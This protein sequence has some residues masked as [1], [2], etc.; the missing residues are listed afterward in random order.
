MEKLKSAD[1]K[2]KIRSLVSGF[3]AANQ[4]PDLSDDEFELQLRRIDQRFGDLIPKQRIGR[5]RGAGVDF[6]YDDRL[7]VP[8]AWA[9]YHRGISGR[10]PIYVQQAL[11]RDL[12][13]AGVLPERL[14]WIFDYFYDRAIVE[15][16]N[17]EAATPEAFQIALQ[18]ILVSRESDI[19]FEWNTKIIRT[20]LREEPSPSQTPSPNPHPHIGEASLLAMGVDQTL[21]GPE[22][23]TGHHRLM[24]PDEETIREFHQRRVEVREL[25]RG[26][27]DGDPAKAE[28]LERMGKGVW[29]SRPESEWIDDERMLRTRPPHL[30]DFVLLRL[31]WLAQDSGAGFIEALQDRFFACAN[32]GKLEILFRRGENKK[33]R[34]C[35][36]LP[37]VFLARGRRRR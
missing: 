18:S 19:A 37:P 33:C 12:V 10:E 14:K 25:L 24:K 1:I 7:V 36:S 29:S 22:P 20:R 6:L 9:V 35:R 32:C 13:R 26:A 28:S 15:V 17:L 2:R 16:L 27:L 23:E 5:G 31:Y 21:N 4:K 3:A 34:S 8:L 11:I 30:V